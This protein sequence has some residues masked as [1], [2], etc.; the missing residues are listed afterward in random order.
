M[1]KDHWLE[2]GETGSG[3]RNAAR[4][5]RARIRLI[6]IT[7]AVVPSKPVSSAIA[8]KI[9]SDCATG[10]SVG[11]PKPGPRPI[12]PR[13]QWPA[14]I[15]R[16]DRNDRLDL[17]RIDPAGDSFAN[18]VNE[19]IA[20]DSCQG[21]DHRGCKQNSAFACGQVKNDSVNQNEYG[22]GAQSR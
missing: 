8:V 3:A 18:Y 20:N 14:M 17:P 21:K 11:L 22:R 19:K 2:Y 12:F 16:F 9:K 7:S 15:E 13:L 10:T 4:K 5:P 6:M 1:Q